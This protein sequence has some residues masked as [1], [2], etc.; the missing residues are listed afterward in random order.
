[1]K[2]TIQRSKIK[3]VFF[4][5]LIT[6]IDDVFLDGRSKIGTKKKSPWLT[7]AQKFWAGPPPHLRSPAYLVV[8]HDLNQ[9]GL[10]GL[11]C[12]LSQVLLHVSTVTESPVSHVDGCS[13][14]WEWQEF[15][16]VTLVL[17]LLAEEI[18]EGVLKEGARQGLQEK[19][20]RSHSTQHGKQG[21][22]KSSTCPHAWHSNGAP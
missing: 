8:I 2:R 22:T 10:H 21:T 14:L 4:F 18:S 6:R 9:P 15:P 12:V 1:M 13:H 5:Y 19:L 20:R 16:I 17:L 11:Q 3:K 7:V